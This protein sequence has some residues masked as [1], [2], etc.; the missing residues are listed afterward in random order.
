MLYL[1]EAR[2]DVVR[3][4]GSEAEHVGGSLLNAAG[5]ATL[6]HP[7][8]ICAWWGRMSAALPWRNGPRIQASRSCPVPIRLSGRP[9]RTP[10]S[11][12]G[13]ATYEFDPTRD[14]PEIA[15]LKSY[16]TC[17]PARSPPPWSSR[18]CTKVVE[19][20]RQIR[21]HATVPCTTLPCVRR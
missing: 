13:R 1:G 3:R 19:A 17:T 18:R 11:D 20:A 15:D 14:V 9:S 16:G 6:G 10:R 8:E 5:A 12:D 2:I 21:D 4:D 7:A